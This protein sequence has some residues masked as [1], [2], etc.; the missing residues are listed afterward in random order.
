MPCTIPFRQKNATTTD[1][2]TC[3]KPLYMQKL[4]NRDLTGGGGEW[5]VQPERGVVTKS[6]YLPMMGRFV[7][8]EIPVSNV[9]SILNYFWYMRSKNVHGQT[10]SVSD[11]PPC[12]HWRYDDAAVMLHS[13]VHIPSH[14]ITLSEKNYDTLC[15]CKATE[16]TSICKGIMLIAKK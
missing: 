14:F 3:A 4:A 13:V 7:K 16:L 5:D 15:F 11:H 2:A 6:Q 1:D 10:L 12:I 8:N 9:K